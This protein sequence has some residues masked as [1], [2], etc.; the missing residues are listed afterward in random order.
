VDVRSPWVETRRLQ[1]QEDHLNLDLANLEQPGD[2]FARVYSGSSAASSDL[3]RDLLAILEIWPA[4]K[5]HLYTL[6]RF[7]PEQKRM[8]AEFPLVLELVD[9]KELAHRL[10]ETQRLYRQRLAH[11]QD[12]SAAVKRAAD[13]AE[14]FAVGEIQQALLKKKGL[15]DD[16]K[17]QFDRCRSL[18]NQT[19]P[20]AH[21]GILAVRGVANPKK[22]AGLDE[23]KNEW[24]S[25]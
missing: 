9:G 5:I 12:T 11:R 14:K 17:K 21:A 18:V 15:S 4:R 20:G 8:Q 24:S 19:Y 16:M 6:D 2:E 10:L 25:P 7:T 1:K 3:L 13:S 22:H 23:R